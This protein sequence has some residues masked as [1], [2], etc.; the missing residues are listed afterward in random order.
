MQNVLCCVAEHYIEKIMLHCV[1]L[2]CRRKLAGGQSKATASDKALGSC[3]SLHWLAADCG[4]QNSLLF[5]C[6]TLRKQACDPL[7]YRESMQPF[8][9]QKNLW[10]LCCVSLEITLKICKTVTYRCTMGTSSIISDRPTESVMH[11]FPSVPF[12]WLPHLPCGD[13]GT[14]ANNMPTVV[15]F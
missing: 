9:K 5:S 12:S 13:R 14:S 2:A 11:I 3:D 10:W 4:K 8:G 7:S 1:L 6:R 15:L